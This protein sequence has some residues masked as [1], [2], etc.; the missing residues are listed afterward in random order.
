[1]ENKIKKVPSIKKTTTIQMKSRSFSVS[2]K[3]ERISIQR[4]LIKQN[5]Y[6]EII[7]NKL[8]SKLLYDNRSRNYSPLIY[9]IK[10][11]TNKENCKILNKKLA[12]ITLLK[13]IHN[14][15]KEM[16]EITSK[17]FKI[18]E[19]LE[20]FVKI[21]KS[22]FVKNN[23]QQEVKFEQK[24][25]YYQ[26]QF[27][28]QQHKQ[29]LEKNVNQVFPFEKP[30]QTIE[31]R[32]KLFIPTCLREFFKTTFYKTNKV[33][34]K[35]EFVNQQNNFETCEY[36]QQITLQKFIKHLLNLE[37]DLISTYNKEFSHLILPVIIENKY[38]INYIICLKSQQIII[39]EE[40]TT[41]TIKN[42]KIEITIK[43][44]H[45][46][47]SYEV[48]FFCRKLSKDVFK[49]TI[50]PLEI[51][52]ILK[53]YKIT[54][55]LEYQNKSI[56]TIIPLQTS[57]RALIFIYNTNPWLINIRQNLYCEKILKNIKKS[58]INLNLKTF[59]LQNQFV[60]SKTTEFFIKS[61]TFYS[62]N[63]NIKKKLNLKSIYGTP[64][65]PKIFFPRYF[66]VENFFKNDHKVKKNNKK[67]NN[68]EFFKPRF[69]SKQKQINV[70]NGKELIIKLR[71]LA[72]P[73]PKVIKQTYLIN[74]NK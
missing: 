64:K 19:K 34:I 73:E 22:L 49:M 30:N 13:T 24:K 35:A 66:T 54:A 70:V 45:L 47:D 11:K 16:S 1:M 8:P 6:E 2:S 57:C 21:K 68:Y 62:I 39:N 27:Y 41:I 12:T 37:T 10:M 5:S 53:F 17:S 67:I 55:P 71:L 14:A 9:S 46:N 29:Q 44:L 38:K 18:K 26:Q 23:Q 50:K 20:I 58:T 31:L 3:N 51:E 52:E 72:N 42:K 40:K 48:V 74:V 61:N 32:V 65:S 28:Y 63:K 59:E 7:F 69:L 25:K 15:K 4:N 60:D 56:A 33:Y 36:V 43:L